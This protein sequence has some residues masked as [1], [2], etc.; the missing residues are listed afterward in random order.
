MKSKIWW[1]ELTL[2]ISIPFL[3]LGL[4]L[5]GLSFTKIPRRAF[6]TIRTKSVNIPNTPPNSMI[7]MQ[8]VSSRHNSGSL[9]D[10][11]S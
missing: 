5:V 4:S 6:N 3:I 10:I 9:R 11:T 8:S 1:L 2:Y 7:D